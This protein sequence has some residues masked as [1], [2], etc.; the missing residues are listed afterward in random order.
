MY[1]YMQTNKQIKINKYE[2]K[3]NKKYTQTNKYT[4]IYIHMNTVDTA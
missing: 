3:I 1:I 4:Y 2:Q